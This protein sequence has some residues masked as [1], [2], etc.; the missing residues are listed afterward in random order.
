MVQ[1]GNSP[2]QEWWS[3]THPPH[4]HGR[5][6]QHE[7]SNTSR[8]QKPATWRQAQL[9]NQILSFLSVAPVKSKELSEKKEI[10]TRNF[11]V[12]IE[13]IAHLVFGCSKFSPETVSCPSLAASKQIGC[14]DFRTGMQGMH[15][16]FPPLLLTSCPVT[17]STNLNDHPAD[18]ISWPIYTEP[19]MDRLNREE[20]VLH[21]PQS[22]QFSNPVWLWNS[23]GPK[24]LP[25]SV[26]PEPAF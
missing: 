21:H 10:F 23:L 19:R 11:Q 26:G 4:S 22:A 17:T 3:S 16:S 15:S 2:R 7:H 12:R 20:F 6:A 13:N 25:H 1:P 8:Q 9:W 14:T 18:H 5:I 24:T